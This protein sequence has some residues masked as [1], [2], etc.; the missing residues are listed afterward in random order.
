MTAETAKPANCGPLVTT[1]SWPPPRE[2]L[3]LEMFAKVRLCGAIETLLCTAQSK[4]GTERS[5][6]VCEAQSH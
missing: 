1:W 3:R 6:Y 2:D 5:S 4:G